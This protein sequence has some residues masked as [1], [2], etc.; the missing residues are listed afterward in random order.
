MLQLVQ[1]IH[2]HTHTHAYI[3]LL[4]SLRLNSGNHNFYLRRFLCLKPQVLALVR[5]TRALPSRHELH[6]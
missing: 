6:K 4:M 2:T 1:E 3:H 5:C